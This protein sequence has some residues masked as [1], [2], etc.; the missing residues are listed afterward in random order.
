MPQFI[1]WNSVTPTAAARTYVTTGTAIKTMLQLATPSTAGLKVVRWGVR[2]ASAPT[3][4]VRCELIETTSVAATVTAHVAA[5]ISPYNDA[6][7]GLASVLVPGLSTTTTGYT[8]TA[9]GSVTGST[10]V[11]DE[12]QIPIGISFYDYEWALGREFQI[13]PSKILRARM[14]TGTAVDAAVYIVWD[15]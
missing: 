6:S 10:R 9:E 12:I 3:A 7:A 2:F 4:V 15:E 11:A 13:A 5:G 14:T 8:A 1:T